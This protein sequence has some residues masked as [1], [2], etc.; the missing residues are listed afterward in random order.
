MP[1]LHAALG[2]NYV[3]VTAL[4]GS[5]LAQFI[6]VILNL[7]LPSFYP[8][9]YVGCGRYAQLPLGH[10]MRHGSGYRALLRRHFD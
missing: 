1:L 6:K 8:G 5:F 10:R 3:L 2:W 9:A 4:C 7:H